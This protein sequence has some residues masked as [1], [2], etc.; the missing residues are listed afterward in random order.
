M[1]IW[2][3]ARSWRFC[4]APSQKPELRVFLRL[5]QSVGAIEG[6]ALRGNEARVGD[7]AAEFDF[8]GAVFYACGED[9]V[10][11]DEDAADVVGTEL[12]PNLADFDSR[13]KPARLDVVNVVE[14]QAADGQRLEIIHSC[15]FLHFLAERGVFRRKHPG[16]ERRETTRVFLNPPQPLQ[17][18]HAVA[19]FLA[20]AKHHCGCGSQTEGMRDAVHFFPLHAG[21]L[22]PGN[23]GTNLI[24]EDLRAATWNRLQPGLHEPLDG[25]AHAD[26]AYFRD[27]Q[28]FRRRNAV[29]AHL[30]VAGLQRAQQIFVVADL[31]I[32]MQAAL[33]QNSC[34]SQFQHLIDF[35]VNFL[36]RQYVAVL[37]PQ[38]TVER[39]KGAVFGA[40]IRVIDVAVDLVSNDTRIVF[41]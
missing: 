31:Q 33:E 12:Q 37:C 27:T 20:A 7:D 40:E 10:F 18:V 9:Y 5:F 21:A 17:V 38:G 15:R 32:G 29:Q 24:V 39:A 13:G 3:M 4:F 26:L 30:R 2:R 25:F 1:S 19:Q 16:N 36:E 41:L 11:F 22:Q 23:L 34:S 28:N 35:F 8:I 6:I 14:V